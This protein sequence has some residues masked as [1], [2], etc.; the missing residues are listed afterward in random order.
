MVTIQIVFLHRLQ[1]LQ[2]KFEDFRV[3]LHK[4]PPNKIISQAEFKQ[5]IERFNRYS[6]SCARSKLAAERA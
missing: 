6:S 3:G 1:V 2:E 4:R 5:K